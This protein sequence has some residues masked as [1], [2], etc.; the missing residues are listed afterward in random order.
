MQ[1]MAAP[2]SLLDK[3]VFPS[4]SYPE[5]KD[6]FERY[7]SA[8]AYNGSAVIAPVQVPFSEPAYVPKRKQAALIVRINKMVSAA[9]IALWSLAILGYGLDVSASNEVS[10]LQDRARRLSEQNTEL[11]AKVLKAISFQGIQDRAIGQLSLTV[12][13]QVLIVKEV[14]PYQAA[15]F[16]P[17]KHHLPLLPGF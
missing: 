3:D 9:T 2:V 13:E 4:S 10:R 7:T 11:S 6:I 12:P 17:Q 8:V 5:P 14:P 15:E 1:A 16:H